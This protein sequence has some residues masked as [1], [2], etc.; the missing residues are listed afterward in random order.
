MRRPQPTPEPKVVTQQRMEPSELEV[1][2]MQVTHLRKQNEELQREVE[3]Y[4][5]M[6]VQYNQTHYSMPQ[7]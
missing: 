7:H 4:R 5:S 6:F 1:L 2:R 3:L